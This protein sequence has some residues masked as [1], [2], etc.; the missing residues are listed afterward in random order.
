TGTAAGTRNRRAAGN[1]R[2]RIT[3][4]VHSSARPR[5]A[6]ATIDTSRLLAP[7][8][9]FVVAP[10]CAAP[11]QI[12]PPRRPVPQIRQKMPLYAA[13]CPYIGPRTP[14]RSLQSRANSRL[15]QTLLHVTVA[16]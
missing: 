10:F 4:P 9:A 12:R 15:A 8:N 16:Q 7:G 6:C 1:H 2:Q 3:A 13:A 5:T 11:A 14:A